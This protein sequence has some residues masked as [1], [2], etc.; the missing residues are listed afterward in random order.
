M[1]DYG[2][3]KPGTDVSEN[4]CPLVNDN[5]NAINLSLDPECSL[6]AFKKKEM[7]YLKKLKESFEKCKG[8][9]FCD[10]YTAIF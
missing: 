5:Q 7:P 1:L 9:N 3:K 6:E 4:K 2:L 10:L 8:K